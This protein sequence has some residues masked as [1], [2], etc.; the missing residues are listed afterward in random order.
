VTKEVVLPDGQSYKFYYNPYG[1]LARVELPTGGAVEYD[2]VPG[3]GA[4]SSGSDYQIYRRVGERRVYPDGGTG[5]AFEGRMTYSSAYITGVG[6]AVT[7]DRLDQNGALLARTKHYYHGSASGSLFD[8]LPTGYMPWKDGR[9]YKTEEFDTANCT[10]ATCAAVLRR[11]EQTWQQPVAGA[12]WPLTNP[13]TDDSA[14]S[15]NPQVTQVL[16]TLADTNQ[17]SKQTFAYDKYGNK[18]DAYEYDY[19]AGAA[20]A[21]LR[22]THTD[23]V[24]TNTVNGLSYDYACDPATAC[25][26]QNIVPGIVHLRALPRRQWVSSDA[27]GS[28]KVAL[29]TY[30]YDQ[31]GLTDRSGITGMCTTFT[32]AQCSSTNSAA[33]VTRG[34]LTGVTRYADAPDEAG[35]VTASAAYDIAGN[36]VSTTN[37]KGHT[38]Q[39]SYSDS[40]CNGSACG[41]TFTANT[42]AFAAGTTSPVPDVSTAYGFPAGT[43]G[44]TV[45]FTST[46]VYDF[47][48]GLVYSATDANSK[49]TTFEYGDGLDRPTAE[50]R[51]DGSRTDFQYNDAVGDLY[52]RV[53]SDLSGARRI[54]MRRYFDGLGRP[55][56]SLTYENQVPATPWLAAD[57]QYDALGRV[58]RA[59]LSY[60]TAGGAAPL[61]P[62]QWSNARR[63][64][65]E[66]D[67]LGRVK[68]VT[69]LP[70]TAAVTTSYSGNTMRVTDQA[71][72][73]RRS[74]SDAVGR[75]RG[76]YEDPDGVNYLTSYDYDVLGNLRTVT[77][78][79]QA[80][81]TFIY[82]SLGRLT[83]A[84]H[85]ESGVTGYT[86]DENGNPLTRTDARGVTASYTYDRLDRQIITTYVG[87]GT[88][89][90]EIR[91]H[92]DGATNGKG[93]LHWSEAVS[94][95]ASVFD[96]YDAVGRPT[97]YHQSFC[98]GSAWG[99]GFGVQRSYNK[100]GAVISQSY[101]SGRTVTYNYDA[102]GRLS[103]D[104]GQPAFRGSLGDGVVR[105]YA[106]EI[107][108]HELGGM[109]LE[110]Y[111]TDTPLYNRKFYNSRGQ[112][113]EIRVG[114]FHP[115]DDGW[116]NR[117]AIV[118]HYS[119]APGAWGS[120]GGGPDNNGNLKKQE[121]YI[122]NQDFPNTVPINDYTNI[123]QEYGYDALNRLTSV[124]DKPGNGAA[125]FYQLYQYDQWGNRTI[126]QNSWNTPKPAFTISQTTNQ[127]QPPA[128]YTITYDPAGNLTQDNF[129]GSGTRAYDA[130]SRIISAQDF[131]GQT[132]AYAYD[133]D[134][135][136]V[137][138]A[139]G[140]GA[141]TWHIY[142][143]DGE[144]LAEYAAGASPSSPLKEYGY[145]GGE[146]L[147]QA[148]APVS[149]GTGLTAH[150]FDNS[151]LTN[152]KLT[153]TDASVNFDWAG[154]SP[155]ATVGADTFSVRWEGKV[156][157]LY[158]QT[159]TFYTLTDDGVRL[160]V[161]GQL[162]IDKWVDQGP[163]EW[164][165]Q[166]ALTAG[167]RYDIRM[168]FY[169]NAGGATAKLLWSSASQAKGVIA[170]SRLY[171]SGAANAQVD[172]RW[173]VADQ[174][175]SPRMVLDKG[176]S[177]AGVRRHD[178][179]PFG[180]EIPA[181]AVWR[182]YERGYADDNVRQEFA[183]KER[184]PETGLD[185]VMARFYSSQQGRF[186]SADPFGP[187]AMSGR[188]KQAFLS[189]PQQWNRYSYVTNNPLRYTDPDGLLKFDASV[190]SSQQE[191]ILSALNRI[192]ATGTEKQKAIANFLLKNDVT[193]R[194]ETNPGFLFDA[195]TDFTGDANGYGPTQKAID[196]GPLTMSQAA[197]LVSITIMDSQIKSG[198]FESVRL[199]GLLVHEGQHAIDYA[200]VA[201]GLSDPTGPN[202]GFDPTQFTMERTGFVAHAEYYMNNNIG[203][204]L[205]RQLGIVEVIP[206][207]GKRGE[208]GVNEIGIRK[209][210]RDRYE[211]LTVHNPGQTRSEHTKLR[212]RQTK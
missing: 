133:A 31:S 91:R 104:N 204:Q 83:S 169:E 88:T 124:Y 193:I 110:Q 148:S 122:P 41:G 86:Y 146:L 71:G 155:H 152:P 33:Y 10:V 177:L 35:A 176:G 197:G 143:I 98:T 53:L 66:Y 57:T 149:A 159:Y 5:A 30:A 147:V 70:D 61:T 138:R 116:W 198:I 25:S 171:P 89:T 63:A 140:A 54:E 162:I 200:R 187:W 20:G 44:S 96:A 190:S 178:Y 135:R 173:L 102:A 202:A 2:P 167:Q 105:T 40:F 163:T 14:K 144:L 24:T 151:N 18:T 164:S 136:R 49:T 189:D 29:T 60:R 212:P 32:G 62:T 186:T 47:Y 211:G 1:E 114:T 175:G 183:G 75:L 181:D 141:A 7:V 194:V 48:T 142:G 160:W 191:L 107:S 188:E 65:T 210:I 6:D 209:L 73:S 92:Y 166:I 115:S 184:D 150:Y 85:P 4:I 109:K 59:S 81:R 165:G 22:R 50:V 106:S 112:L 206:Q 76:V 39:I 46:N 100:A 123:V 38:S 13:E 52:V 56:R 199:E 45:A 101:P 201:Q 43:F 84:S 130:E 68:K 127:L 42:Y 36:V 129:T 37:P 79:T 69:T 156:E 128:G 28:N 154:G 17:V 111:G 16:T 3:S 67:A 132:S 182:T 94:V 19:G 108:Y 174:L 103:D 157:P 34:N 72:K 208:I 95:S 77:Q 27:A 99:Q 8:D 172:L 58:A 26:N 118:N 64:E 134:G 74:V 97:Q 21:L 207:E 153:R 12:T 55:Y 126:D 15:N 180:E 93:R 78:G 117:G 11:T 195:K 51:P 158:S 125:D 82:D 170:Q 196:S 179:L 131:Y 192:L 87:G 185:Y 161:N 120:H 139:Q 121:T 203:Q 90:P 145:R 119:N 137:R 205:G 23:Y 113:A 168:E 80:A 9:E